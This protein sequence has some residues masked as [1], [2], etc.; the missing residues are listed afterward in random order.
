MKLSY[1]AALI[2]SLGLWSVQVVAACNNATVRGAYGYAYTAANFVSQ[3]SCG[4]VGLIRL[5]GVN[6]VKVTE[7]LSCNGTAARFSGQ[8]AYSI[9]PNC[10]GEAFVT[11]SDASTGTY[12]FVVVN[13]GKAAQFVITTGGITGV[14]NAIKR[15]Q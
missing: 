6:A 5:D 12:S 10:T 8:G 3:L 2:L 1:S 15:D 4:G 7:T 9:R 11:F 14:G 13:N